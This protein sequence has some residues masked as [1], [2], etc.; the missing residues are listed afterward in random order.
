MSVLTHKRIVKSEEEAVN[1][2]TFTF[3]E[4]MLAAGSKAYKE[5]STRYDIK[6]KRILV[7]IGK[8]NNG[9]DGCVIARLLADNGANTFVCYPLGMPITE[10]AKYYC[11]L[12]NDIPK[13]E[14]SDNFDFVI[15]A[16]FGIGYRL[17][18]NTEIFSKINEIN[19]IK[20]S[21]DIPSGVECDTGHIKNTAVK[22]A[23]TLTFIALKPCFILPQGS[24][25]CGEVKVLDIG[26]VPVKGEFE[27]IKEPVFK[28]RLPSSHKGSYGTA[29][30]FCGSYGFAGAL[31][32]SAKAALRSGVGIVKCVVHKS[33]YAPFTRFLPEAVCIPF[34]KYRLK[35]IKEILKGCDSILCGCGSGQSKATKCLIKFLIKNA[36]SP[37][38]L[39]ADGINVITDCID[40]L[41]KHTAPLI[42]T[43]H[44]G[45]MARLCKVSI[46]EIEAQR[47]RFAKEIAEKYNCIV[48]LKGGNTLVA[49]PSGKVSVN[50]LGNPGM[51]TGGSG[52][53]LAGVI[54]SLLAQGFTPENAAK[55]GVYL[56]S[57]AADK[58]AA[59]RSQH[60]LL[61]TDIIEE[62]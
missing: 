35:F 29:L 21:I 24:D 12:I 2:G 52:D 57:L 31:M 42:L 56:H 59:K 41:K 10:N 17:S 54:V 14:L 27:I 44:P 26:V 16:L 61:P 25:Y 32:L 37:L 33:I 19:A 3:K 47:P 15:D 9:G 6:N 11:D 22:A 50:L 49:E 40:I 51:A 28:K 13:A 36:S 7:V 34:K 53:A 39:D 60:A 43:P 55:G 46:M 18:E 20:I 58:A 5:I 48:V 23:L 8:G 45:E 38:I 30:L 62:L 4:L 1:N